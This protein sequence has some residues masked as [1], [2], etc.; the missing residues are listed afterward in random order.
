MTQSQGRE[1]IRC[2]TVYTAA[3]DAVS[4]IE[5][6]DVSGY[7]TGTKSWSADIEKEFTYFKLSVLP[8]IPDQVI[9]PASGVGRWI[10]TDALALVEA[11]WATVSE[12]TGWPNKWPT[13]PPCTVTVDDASRTL[14][15]TPTPSC[16]FYL[17]GVKFTKT[18]PQTVVWPDT[19]GLNFFYFDGNGVLRTTTSDTVW[20]D[21]ILG[22]GVLVQSIYWDKP[23]ARH[24]RN[25]EERHGFMPGPTHI[26]FHNAFGARLVDGGALF[27]FNGGGAGNAAADAQFAVETTTLYDE[28]VRMVHPT[29]PFPAS[30]P[31]F[32]LFGASPDWRRK[33]ADAF[34]EIY[35]GTAGYVGAN[36]R[37]AVNTLIAGSYGLTEMTADNHFVDGFAFTSNDTEEPDFIVWGTV[38]YANVADATA[39]AKTELPTIEALVRLMNHEARIL[40]AYICESAAGFGNTPKCRIVQTSDGGDYVDSRLNDVVGVPN[41]TTVLSIFGRDGV[42][43][44]VAGDY[45][46]SQVTNDSGVA[47]AFVSVALDNLDTDIGVV[48]GN[49]AALA[50]VVATKADKAI[51]LTAGAGLT[52]G[53]DLSANRTFT[54]VANADG[55]IVVN[56]DDIQ[57]GVISDAQHGNRGGGALHALAIAG[58]AAGFQSGADKLKE[59][60]IRAGA[61]SAA[62]LWGNA[63]V[64]A[65]TTTRFMTP[66]YSTAVAPT[67]TIQFRV[68][69]A[70]TLKNLRIRCRTAPGNGNPIVYTLQVNAG[71]TT[72][73]VSLASNAQDGA[74]LA[75]SVAVVAGDLIGITVTKAAAVGS[76]P[77]DIMASL[78][79]AA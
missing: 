63:D 74:D 19:Q 29:L 23:N 56:A 76:S 30:V 72:V 26:E 35:S 8:A 32:Y 2:E 20:D 46:A 71:N 68:P 18:T 67:T 64:T 34:P 37:L 52:G 16:D 44:A 11:V 6:L 39:G 43:I 62:L 50:G 36:G 21:Q 42:V 7:I 14:T 10:L 1:E 17:S 27:G 60:G 70:G 73:S 75:H 49:L 41:I 33:D 66:G 77:V 9:V 59:D 13:P 3:S 54:V 25:A 5:G 12:P 45:A 61:T 24:I 58:G 57:V 40:G 28:D 31:V 47:G 48:A 51:T 4:S 55:S 38:E 22:S 15:L 78:E 53:G 65:S 79:L 69:F